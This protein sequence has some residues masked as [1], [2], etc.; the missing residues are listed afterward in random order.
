MAV[1]SVQLGV[2]V[3]AGVSVATIGDGVG[4]RGFD[5]P[6]HA[7]AMTPAPINAPATK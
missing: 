1:S 6:E 7:A 4:D 2:A 5:E 3:G